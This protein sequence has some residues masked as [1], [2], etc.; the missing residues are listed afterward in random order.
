MD[1][2]GSQEVD[3]VVTGKQ[4]DQGE[5]AGGQD[6]DPDLQVESKQPG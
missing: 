2:S 1:E 4:P 3:M 5:E 6:R